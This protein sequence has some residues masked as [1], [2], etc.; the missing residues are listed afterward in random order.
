MRGSTP[1][2]GQGELQR[3][4]HSGP[5]A[6]ASLILTSLYGGL[7]SLTMT[8]NRTVSTFITMSWLGESSMALMKIVRLRLSIQYVSRE[9]VI[10][11]TTVN[12]LQILIRHEM[13]THYIIKFKGFFVLIL[14]E[15]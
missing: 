11:K 5:G 12:A 6:A 2:G 7:A 14:F 8:I 1:G 3:Q 13:L 10:S 4:I 9:F 15:G